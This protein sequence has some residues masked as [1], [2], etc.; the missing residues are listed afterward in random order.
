MPE[1][2]NSAVDSIRSLVAEGRYQEAIDE[3]RAQLFEDP[4]NAEVVALMREATAALEGEGPAV[5]PRGGSYDTGEA[6][7]EEEP[8]DSSDLAAEDRERVDTL[9]KEGQALFDDGRLQQAIDAWS[10][11]YIIDL[12]NQRAHRLIEKARIALEEEQRKWDE[13]IQEGNDLLDAGKFDEALAKYREVLD[14][15]PN[16]GEALE[17]VERVESMRR[18]REEKQQKSKELWA[19]AQKLLKDQNYSEAIYNLEKLLELEPKNREAAQ[20]LAEAK[21]QS[22]DLVVSNAAPVAGKGKKGAAPKAASSA[23][24][25]DL[26]PDAQDMPVASVKRSNPLPKLVAVAFVASAIVG[27]ATYF[28]LTM[29]SEV[30]DDADD[31]VV[32]TV[33]PTVMTPAAPVEDVVPVALEAAAVTAAEKEIGKNATYLDARKAFN[34]GR[35]EQAASLYQAALNELPGNALVTQQ[36][37]RC[38][39]NAGVIALR[40]GDAG[41]AVEQWNLALQ[42]DP[43]DTVTKRNLEAAKRYAGAPSDDRIR[44]YAQLSSLRR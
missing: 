41:K 37:H 25:L 31:P 35:F 11:I 1:E 22:G 39:Y 44:W 40:G 12:N 14:S 23:A 3:C 20:A 34:D 15:N 16:H 17:A 9:V 30:P 19:K 10:R 21:R 13:V 26:S 24:S 2:P 27:G 28:L 5:A 29:G 32:T 42:M 6:E 36:L 33:T 4:E 8:A 38:Y 7:E 43:T 18:Q